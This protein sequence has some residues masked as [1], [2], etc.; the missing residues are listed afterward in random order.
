MNRLR[1]I[2][3]DLQETALVLA[4]LHRGRGAVAILQL[5]RHSHDLRIEVADA[6]GAASGNVKLDIQIV[7]VAKEFHVGNQEVAFGLLLTLAA[8]PIGAL[9]FGRLADR[10]GRRPILMLDVILFSVFELAT[11]FSTSGVS[12]TDASVSSGT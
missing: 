4:D 10:Y 5:R 12:G 6:L 7:G 9:L 11:A 1:F 2:L 8:R 3:R